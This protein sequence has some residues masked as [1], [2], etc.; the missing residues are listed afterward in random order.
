[1]EIIAH[2]MNTAPKVYLMITA[3]VRNMTHTGPNPLKKVINMYMDYWKANFQDL[4]ETAKGREA[5]VV[6]ADG[7]K[8][9]TLWKK[10]KGNC[11][12][13]VSKATRM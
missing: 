7:P 4:K 3:M 11:T 13:W 1:M 2:T 8:S 6:V 12:Y 5:L 9:K 10:F